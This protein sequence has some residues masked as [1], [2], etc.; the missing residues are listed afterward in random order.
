MMYME[1]TNPTPEQAYYLYNV[2]AH[3]RWHNFLSK[4]TEAFEILTERRVPH[5]RKAYS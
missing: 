5:V 4:L 1:L 3:T 2:A